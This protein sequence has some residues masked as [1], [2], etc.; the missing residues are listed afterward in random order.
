MRKG[1]NKPVFSQ[2]CIQTFFLFFFSRSALEKNVKKNKTTSV[3]RL[4]FRSNFAKRNRRLLAVYSPSNPKGQGWK[5]L[6]FQTTILN[7]FPP[8]RKLVTQVA[9][10]F[11]TSC[12]ENSRLTLDTELFNYPPTTTTI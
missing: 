3:S 8:V 7:Y 1:L 9:V 10:E 4:E 11:S 12:G 6:I 5:R 2:R